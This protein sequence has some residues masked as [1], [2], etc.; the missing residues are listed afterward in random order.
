MNEIDLA[1]VFQSASNAVKENREMIN[2]ADSLHH[3]HGDN[4][5]EIFNV[6]VDAVQQKQDVPPAQ[7][8][9]YAGQELERQ[10]KS[11]TAKVYVDGL[12]QASQKF[13]GKE[14]SPNTAVDFIQTLL[15]GKVESETQTA[16]DSSFASQLLSGLVPSD[17]AA[18]DQPT[19]MESLFGDLLTG[20]TGT[21]DESESG[22]FDLSDIMQIGLS[23]MQAKQSGSGNLN[24]IVSAIMSQT[25]MGQKQHR[26]ASGT[27]VTQSLLD[28]LIQPNN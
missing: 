16:G 12:K 4:M 27:V 15:G 3:D 17:Q 5:V 9:D 20:L 10:V 25:L 11:S 13:S 24:A 14:I 28:A 6:I 26:A 1:R 8:L 7:Q 2:E 22:K 23:F 21:V 19:G 18:D